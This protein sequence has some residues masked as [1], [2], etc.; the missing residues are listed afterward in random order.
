MKRYTE[1]EHLMIGDYVLVKYAGTVHMKEVVSITKRKVGVHFSNDKTTYFRNGEWKHV[2]LSGQLLEGSGFVYGNGMACYRKY[3]ANRDTI[4]VTIRYSSMNNY[5]SVEVEGTGGPTWLS[6]GLHSIK[7]LYELQHIL[8]TLGVSPDDVTF[9]W[10][11]PV[12]GTES[13]TQEVKWLFSHFGVDE[14]KYWEMVTVINWPNCNYKEQ[15]EHISRFGDKNT[16]FELTKA[17]RVIV[18]RAVRDKELWPYGELKVGDDSF[19][20]ITAHMVGLGRDVFYSVLEEPKKIL[21][22]RNSFKENFEYCFSAD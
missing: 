1:S 14:D 22:Y 19:W 5:Y 21:E 13:Y 9:N 6:M 12:I 3:H 18:Q 8:R 7:Y 2:K 10:S 20:D 16:M 17:L 4:T 11:E 15:K